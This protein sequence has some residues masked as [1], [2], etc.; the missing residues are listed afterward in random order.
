[1]PAV[2]WVH[3]FE[4]RFEPPESGLKARVSFVHSDHW[5]DEYWKPLYDETAIEEAR[6]A[7]ISDCIDFLRSSDC[8]YSAAL[9][10]RYVASG[11]FRKTPA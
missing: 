11:L 3:G 6:R 7:A 8:T 2:A 5:T 10:D 4:D 1:M 9:L